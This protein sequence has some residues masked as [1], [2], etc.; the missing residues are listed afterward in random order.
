MS[1]LVWRVKLTAEL[2]PGVATETELARIERGEAAGP[3]E[4]GLRLE[5]GKRLTAALQAEIVSA[6]VGDRR[7]RA[8]PLVCSLRSTAGRQ[9]AL[10]G[11]LP[12]AVR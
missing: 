11:D 6:Q 12:L 9:G 4:L 8:P 2:E 3:A 5:E 1:K 10:P 7:G